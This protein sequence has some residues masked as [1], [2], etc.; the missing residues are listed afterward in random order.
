MKLK[1][2]LVVALLSLI[3]V[4]CETEGYLDYQVR[5]LSG[6]DVYIGYVKSGDTVSVIIPAN[7]KDFVYNYIDN[8]ADFSTDKVSQRPSRFF[9]TIYMELLNPA[10]TC[11]KDVLNDKDWDFYSSGKRYAYYTLT[12]RE[13]DFE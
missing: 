5:N 13:F 10:I 11:N 7:T 9:D 6:M 4:S 2:L 8:G 3:F 1:S 12:L